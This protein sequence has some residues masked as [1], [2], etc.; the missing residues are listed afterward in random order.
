MDDDRC[1]VRS[2]S[3][4]QEMAELHNLVISRLRMAMVTNIAA[5]LGRCA[6]QTLPCHVSR[7]SPIP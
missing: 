7:G 5:A 6:T 1:R 3:A 4:P 2:G